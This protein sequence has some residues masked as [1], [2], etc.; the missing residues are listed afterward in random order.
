VFFLLTIRFR[1]SGYHFAYGLIFRVAF[2]EQHDVS[3]ERRQLL[4]RVKTVIIITANK[5]T[6]KNKTKTINKTVQSQ[7]S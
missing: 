2:F 4:D 1:L 5:K 7:D 3:R 6:R